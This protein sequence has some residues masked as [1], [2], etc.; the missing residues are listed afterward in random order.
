MGNVF[1]LMDQL[2]DE[3]YAPRYNNPQQYQTQYQT[4]YPLYTTTRHSSAP[5]DNTPTSTEE[6]NTRQSYEQLRYERLRRER[7]KRKEPEKFEI[8]QEEYAKK[9]REQEA[10][11]GLRLKDER[12]KHKA[13]GINYDISYQVNKKEQNK[14]FI[15]N[16]DI[17][18]NVEYEDNYLYDRQI[19]RERY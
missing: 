14:D 17:R 13:Y 10:L 7:I 6:V 9:L 15:S 3:A 1:S 18:Q 11:E 8:E 2:V 12:E 5:Y 4:Q 16:P 19:R